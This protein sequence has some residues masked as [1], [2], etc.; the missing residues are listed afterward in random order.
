M[1]SLTGV[2]LAWIWTISFFSVP[3]AAIVAQCNWPETEIVGFSGDRS[4]LSWKIIWKVLLWTRQVVE[5]GT[6]S[7]YQRQTKTFRMNVHTFSIHN[8]F[9]TK[10]RHINKLDPIFLRWTWLFVY[11]YLPLFRPIKRL[12][13]FK[14]IMTPVIPSCLYNNGIQLY[15]SSG[16]IST[17]LNWI[18]KC[19]TIDVYLSST[20]QLLSWLDTFCDFCFRSF[21]DN[22]L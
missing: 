21:H 17:S 20:R 2:H 4:L 3:L 14:F 9:G 13:F 12:E 10:I 19:C 15:N 7:I 11:V 8:R 5:N 6:L 1:L 16:L 22:S 18:H